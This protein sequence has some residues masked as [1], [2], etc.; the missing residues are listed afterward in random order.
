[1]C[2][3]RKFLEPYVTCV[4]RA[5]R[6]RQCHDKIR[7]EAMMRQSFRAKPKSF[8]DAP[9]R[10]WQFDAFTWLLRGCGG[11]PRFLDTTLVLPISEHFPERG[12]RGHAAAAA[13]FRNVRDHAGMAEWPCIVEPEAGSK[14]VEGA[15]SSRSTR[16]R[17][18]HY[19]PS[20]GE[21]GLLVAH[22][23]H[24]LARFLV[25]NFDEPPP[26]GAEL[27]EPAVELAAVFLG[28]GVFMANSAV[29]KCPWN[30]NEG[31]LV[32]ALALFC[33]LRKLPGE[34]AEPYLNAHLRKYLRLAQ[35]DLAQFDADFQR[36]R[37]V[38]GASPEAGEGNLAR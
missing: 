35:R 5:T 33:L 12:M 14:A 28:F 22:F 25:E 31:E 6:V 15:S 16:L 29:Q 7:R 26:G 18:I 2:G 13:L 24:E 11:F 30:L 4:I 20:E 19:P 23:A 36:L 3:G 37:A 32:H 10:Q 38:S 9:R 21:P 8:L 34:G 17:V 1:L 27:Y